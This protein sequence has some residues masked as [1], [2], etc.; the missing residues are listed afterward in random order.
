MTMFPCGLQ[1]Y[2]VCLLCLSGE[3]NQ[4]EEATWKAPRREKIAVYG[5]LACCVVLAIACCV[6]VFFG[7]I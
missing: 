1:L 3:D 4:H 5:V 6:M 7:G 2:A